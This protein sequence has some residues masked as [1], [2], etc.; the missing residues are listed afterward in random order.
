[1]EGLQKQFPN[2]GSPLVIV[3]RIFGQCDL[4][5]CQSLSQQVRGRSSHLSG[6]TIANKWLC[7]Y[8]VARLVES[9]YDNSSFNIP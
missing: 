8:R 5:R 6:N 9:L 1:M 4:G 7:H 2:N 3:L